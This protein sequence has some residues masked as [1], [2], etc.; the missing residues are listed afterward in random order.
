[1]RVRSDGNW[2]VTERNAGNRALNFH[3]S[4]DFFFPPAVLRKLL[5]IIGA[6]SASSHCSFC[7]Q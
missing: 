1:M 7:L 2:D 4:V 3:V 5:H 6:L